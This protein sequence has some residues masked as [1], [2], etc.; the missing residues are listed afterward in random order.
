MSDSGRRRGKKQAEYS[1]DRLFTETDAKS[2]E[3]SGYTMGRGA[4][5]SN[6]FMQDYTMPTGVGK[7][8]TIEFCRETIRTSRCLCKQ[9]T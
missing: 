8:V 4:P 9:W 7:F 1:N 2:V 5:Q 6:E 3:M